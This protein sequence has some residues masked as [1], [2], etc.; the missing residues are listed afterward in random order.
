[1]ASTTRSARLGLRATP[2]QEAVLRRAAEVAN[3]S[4]TDFILDSACLAAE[5]TLLD[6]R[7]F[8]VSGSQSQALLDMLDRPAQDNPGLKDLFSRSAPWDK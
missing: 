4:M 5:Q 6:Q 7:L 8:L 1:M 3:K 2:Q